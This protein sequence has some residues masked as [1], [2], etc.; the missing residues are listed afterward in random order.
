MVTTTTPW[1]T[2]TANLS[3]C[4]AQTETFDLICHMTMFQEELE[5]PWQQQQHIGQQQ[6]HTYPIVKLRLRHLI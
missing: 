2:A 1:S 6:L 5:I 3:H 4:K